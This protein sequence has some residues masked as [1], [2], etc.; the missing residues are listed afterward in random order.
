MNANLPQLPARLPGLIA[1]IGN[2]GCGPGSDTKLMDEIIHTQIEAATRQTALV[3][4][5]GSRAKLLIFPDG[6][7]LVIPCTSS[8]CELLTEAPY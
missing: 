5:D 3:L 6:H 8:S 1:L 7:W 4:S 2:Y